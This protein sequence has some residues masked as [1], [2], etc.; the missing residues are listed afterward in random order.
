MMSMVVGIGNIAANNCRYGKGEIR[1]RR[2]P[3]V[4]ASVGADTLLGLRGGQKSA[5][6]AHII[7]I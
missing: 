6:V 3:K 7:I 2:M 1:G 5:S 4:L